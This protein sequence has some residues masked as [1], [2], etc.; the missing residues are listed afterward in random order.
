MSKTAILILAAGES[1]RLGKPKQL[2]PYKKTSLLSH[3]I[4]QVKGIENS[5]VFVVVG[6]YFQEVFQSIRTEGVTVLK[7]NDWENGMGSSI[8]KGIQFIKKKNAFDRVLITLSDIPLVSNSHYKELISLSVESRK[9][10]I[11]TEYDDTSGVPVVF[12]K[13]LF[14]ALSLLNNDEGAKPIIDKYKKEV[15]KLQSKTPYFD[16]DTQ[17]AY[18]KLLELS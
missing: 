9:R 15:L 4:S 11:L 17:D 14:D 6:A 3:A 12:D 16:V 5:Q 18:Q 1:K 7:N 13:S 8:S 10:I 2:L